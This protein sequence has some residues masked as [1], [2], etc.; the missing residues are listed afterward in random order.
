MKVYFT[1]STRNTREFE[2][3]YEVILESISKLG[4]DVV[5]HRKNRNK[6]IEG[7]DKIKPSSFYK[8][9]MQLIIEADVC[10]FDTSHQSMRIGHQLTY[11]LENSTPVLVLAHQ[12][13]GDI[14]SFFITGSKSGYLTIYS[15]TSSYELKDIIPKFLASNKFSKVRFNLAIEKHYSDFMEQKAKK[16]NISKTDVI[17]QALENLK[18]KASIVE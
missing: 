18:E 5:Y 14:D 16:E 6:Q 9:M 11:A 1:H 15:Y 7:S 17:K 10:I 3:Y 13:A 4:H 8:E 12:S 2:R